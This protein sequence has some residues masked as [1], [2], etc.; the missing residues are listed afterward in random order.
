MDEDVIAGAPRGSE[1]AGPSGA[2]AMETSEQGASQGEEGEGRAEVTSPRSPA[3]VAEARRQAVRELDPEA[4]LAYE[5]VRARVH[6]AGHACAARA[7][8]QPGAP[9]QQLHRRPAS[10]GPGNLRPRPSRSAPGG[11]LQRSSL[12]LGG[13][14]QAASSQGARPRT[15]PPRPLAL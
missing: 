3:A 10:P 6:M 5:E 8:Q 11:P 2:T 13:R 1:G 9:A 4:L 15:P 14:R 12:P 7:R